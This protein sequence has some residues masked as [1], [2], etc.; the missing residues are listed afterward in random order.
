MKIM[1]QLN[2]TSVPKLTP[3][4]VNIK[5]IQLLTNMYNSFY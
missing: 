2:Q 3:F 5:Q 1:R 4:V